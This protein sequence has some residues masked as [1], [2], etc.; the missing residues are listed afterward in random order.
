M[1]KQAYIIYIA[2][3]MLTSTIFISGCTSFLASSSAVTVISRTPTIGATAVASTENLVLVFNKAMDT[4]IQLNDA[5]NF[6]DANNTAGYPQTYESAG[7]STGDTTLT[8]VSPGN[9][10]GSASA[11]A[12]WLAS[13]EGFADEDGNS[14]LEGTVLLDFQLE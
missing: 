12:Y 2:V 8:I 14:L 3:L 9:W 7:W 4:S 1:N 6:D 11:R 13:N 10:S 5:I